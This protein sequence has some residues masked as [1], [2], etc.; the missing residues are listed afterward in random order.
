MNMNTEELDTAT[1]SN[2]PSNKWWKKLS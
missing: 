2:L 1:T